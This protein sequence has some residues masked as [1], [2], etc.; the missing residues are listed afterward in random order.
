MHEMTRFSHKTYLFY[1]FKRLFP[2]KRIFAYPHATALNYFHHY[3]KKVFDPE[4][5]TLLVFDEKSGSN[6]RNLGY[7]NQYVV[8]FPKFFGGWTEYL[9]G[10]DG[11][12]G[13]EPC[14]VI[15]SRGIH[16]ISMDAE[17]YRYLYESAYR[18]IRE[19]F[20]NVP[21]LVKLHPR[22]DRAVFEEIRR[23]NRMENVE[24]VTLHP[25]VLAR[26]AL[27]TVSYY[28]SAI[29]DAL[30]VGVPSVDYYVESRRFREIE[31]MGSIYRLVGIDSVDDEAGLAAFFDRVIAGKYEPPAIMGAGG[32]FRH[33]DVDFL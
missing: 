4:N 16:P 8:G 15:Y 20:G 19:K 17:N 13:K 2:S 29:L 9:R 6:Y 1:L 32:A 28:T 7:E 11:G 18:T 33:V 26:N 21:I 31:T 5:V 27:V 22:E 14:V 30:A 3:K 12:S 10:V 25:A 24:L 23:A